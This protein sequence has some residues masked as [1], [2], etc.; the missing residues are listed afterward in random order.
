MIKP[1]Q[2]GLAILDVE[3]FSGMNEKL[4]FEPK[5]IPGGIATTSQTRSF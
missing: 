2:F 3:G 1:D 5:E 4:E